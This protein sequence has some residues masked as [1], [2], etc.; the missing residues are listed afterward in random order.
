M[1]AR[2]EASGRCGSLLGGRALLVLSLLLATTACGTGVRVLDD[3]EGPVDM[4][5]LPPGPFFEVPVAFVSNFRSGRVAKLDLKRTQRLVEDSPAPWMPGPDLAFGRGYSLGEI[6]LAVGEDSVDLWVADDFEGQIL[7]APYIS[8]LDA[9]GNPVWARPS[10]GE[11]R[12][13]LP[14]GTEFAGPK[15]EL[16]GLRLRPGRATT[17]RWTFTW[18]GFAFEVR[19]TASGLQSNRAVPG[20]PY[21]TD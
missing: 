4:A 16:R 2:P 14:D 9:E 20:T 1:L 6:A 21:T 13:Y 11:L 18:T 17:E 7:R 5:Y 12:A 8:A 3:F 15:P 10:L 19:G